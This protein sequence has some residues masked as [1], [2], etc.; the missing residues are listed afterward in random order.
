M[1]SN[2]LP[3]GP[4]KPEDPVQKADQF[5][6]TAGMVETFP[7]KIPCIEVNPAEPLTPFQPPVTMCPGVHLTGEATFNLKNKQDM[8]ALSALVATLQ[9][10]TAD[11]GHSDD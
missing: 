11:L 5:S 9:A 7:V 4:A 3:Q 6:P 10:Y 2:Y 1:E 8:Q